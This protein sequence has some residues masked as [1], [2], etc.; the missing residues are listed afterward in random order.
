LV[1]FFSSATGQPEGRC[2]G[3]FATLNMGDDG[4]ETYAKRHDADG[5]RTT[6]S[7]ARNAALRNGK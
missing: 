7:W 3:M 1:I 6:A 2:L 4:S 5:G